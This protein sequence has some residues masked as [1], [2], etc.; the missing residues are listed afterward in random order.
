MSLKIHMLH[1]NL[2]FFP[3]NFGK[4][5]DEHGEVFH[6]EIATMEKRSGKVVYFHIG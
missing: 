4:V 2:D 3:Q 6:Q 5:V 1:S